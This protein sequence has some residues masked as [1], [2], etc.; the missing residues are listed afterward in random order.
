MRKKVA[1]VV[2]AACLLFL[3]APTLVSSLPGGRAPTGVPDG[4]R[5]GHV[6]PALAAL[7]MLAAQERPDT[8]GGSP[9]RRDRDLEPLDISPGGAFRRAVAFPGW[10]HA[11]IGA[12]GRGGFY[13]GVQAAI[14][15]TLLRARARIGETQD[16]VRRRESVLL[17]RLTPEARSDFGAV[18]ATFDGDPTLSELRGLLESR[19]RQQEDMLALGIFVVL[20]SGVDAF[21]SAHLSRFPEPL[22]LEARPGPVEG[23]IDIGFRLPL[24][25]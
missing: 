24:P 21:V 16:R 1:H 10:G 15:Y 13:F 4:P 20:I 19:A 14:A 5:G 25:H 3:A 6:R 11:A 23:S 9:E 7:G 18:Q 8:S 2:V 12:H 22:D 17:S